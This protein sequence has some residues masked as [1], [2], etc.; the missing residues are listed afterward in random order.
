MP[1]DELMRA[2]F[3]LEPGETSVAFNEPKTVC[4]VVRLVSLE[5]DDARLK[6]LFLASSEDPRRIATVADDD[7][8]A[9]NENWMKSIVE[10]YG[11][12]WKRDPRGPEL[13]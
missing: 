13:E 8:R 9:V 4:Y 7:M 11:V 12:S 5:P 6:D 10:R 3:E 2:V 1:G